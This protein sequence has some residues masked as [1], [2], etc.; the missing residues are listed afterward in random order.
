MQGAEDLIARNSVA[1][2]G[3]SAKRGLWSTGFAALHPWLSSTG[4]AGAEVPLSMQMIAGER[5]TIRLDV[6]SGSRGKTQTETRPSHGALDDRGLSA[7]FTPSSARL[8]Y[9]LRYRLRGRT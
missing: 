7:M 3:R 6:G 8:V 2:S 1:R 5:H 9:P 4:P